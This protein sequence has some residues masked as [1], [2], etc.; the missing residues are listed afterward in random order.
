MSVYQQLPKSTTTYDKL[1]YIQRIISQDRRV[2]TLLW[3]TTPTQFIEDLCWYTDLDTVLHLLYDN[4]YSSMI[5]PVFVPCWDIHN[6]FIACQ[7][8]WSINVTD[9]TTN[10]DQG[11]SIQLRAMTLSSW[12]E[13]SYFTLS[14]G[15]RLAIFVWAQWRKD[16]EKSTVLACK[17][18]PSYPS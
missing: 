6:T 3:R 18:S 11:V 8:T 1:P 16:R 2:K 12:I 7:G 13:M 14:M 10:Y 4:H 15:F 17:L 9:E 5:T